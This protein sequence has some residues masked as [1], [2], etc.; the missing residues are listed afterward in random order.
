MS[1][2]NDANALRSITYIATLALEFSI[3]NTTTLVAMLRLDFALLSMEID[4]ALERGRVRGFRANQ[5][6]FL[7]PQ[8]LWGGETV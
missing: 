6:V 1:T 4:R 5:F 2:T 3:A 8:W 7:W